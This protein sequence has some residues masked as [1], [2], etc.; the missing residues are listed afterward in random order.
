MDIATLSTE[1][2]TGLLPCVIVSVLLS[3]FSCCF[4]SPIAIADK[5]AKNASGTDGL[6]V[7]LF[8]FK[9][10]RKKGR[11]SD[12]CFRTLSKNCEMIRNTILLKF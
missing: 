10:E 6:F 4:K 1:L 12:L 9:E 8:D 2:I 11:L 5:I 7:E 3:M